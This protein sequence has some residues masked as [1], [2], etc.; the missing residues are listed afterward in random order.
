MFSFTKRK[1]VVD[2]QPYIRRLCNLTAPNLSSGL[3]EGLERTENRYNRTIPTLLV[4][5]KDE[6]PMASEYVVGLTCDVADNGIGLVF[7]QPYRDERV[8]VGY[9]VSSEMMPEPWFFV[10]NIQRNQAI[11]GGF[12]KLGIELTDF[13]NTNHGESLAVLKPL[14]KK[15]LSPTRSTR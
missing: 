13:A 11:G 10:G 15:L 12:W 7:N 14:A 1:K 2:L 9:W 4:P 8:V 6:R 3:V 5:W